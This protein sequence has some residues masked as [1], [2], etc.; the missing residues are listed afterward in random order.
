LIRLNR[1]KIRMIRCILVAENKLDTN[2]PAVIRKVVIDSETN[3]VLK[4]FKGAVIIHCEK[5][6]MRCA[7]RY[8]N[9]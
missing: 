4:G 3:V 1:F 8:G 7:E 9:S 6:V 2:Q 5:Q